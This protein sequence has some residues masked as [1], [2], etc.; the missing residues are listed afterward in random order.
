MPIWISWS[1]FFLAPCACLISVRPRITSLWSRLRL[2]IAVTILSVLV[3][4][5]GPLV[6]A[7]FEST[8][9]WGTPYWMFR[10]AYSSDWKLGLGLLGD[11]LRWG[12]FPG[13]VTALVA[14]SAHGWIK[15]LVWSVVVISLCFIILDLAQ[16]DLG[17][18]KVTPDV[19]YIV[20]VNV[21]GGLLAGA[22][23][24][25]AAAFLERLIQHDPVRLPLANM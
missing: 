20:N 10:L 17:Y 4:S 21:I 24:G 18:P 16:G 14:T 12:M 3:A 7:S 22:A 15:K 13:A 19:G 23:I 6:Q 25:L 2:G 5:T 8:M 1:A 9:L 11:L